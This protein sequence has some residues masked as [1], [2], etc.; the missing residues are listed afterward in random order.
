M[1][2]VTSNRQSFPVQVCYATPEKQ[3]LL[4]VDVLPETRL[5]DAILKSG[6]LDHLPRPPK[7]GETGIFGRKKPFD[8]VL[9]AHD[10]IEIY[11]PLPVSPAEM[12]RHRLRN[13]P[14][15]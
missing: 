7:E 9:K 4:D 12:R 2:N 3:L 6:I 14:Q 5:I 15:N 11:R 10:R 1:D 13:R 8:T